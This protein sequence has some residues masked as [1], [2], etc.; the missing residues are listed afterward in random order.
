[1]AKKSN[2][3]PKSKSPGAQ[4]AKAKRTPAKKKH[5]AREQRQA[6]MEQQK[7]RIQAPDP[8]SKE[9]LKKLGLRLGIGAAV[10]WGIAVAIPGTVAKV[11]AGVITVAVLGA[12]V[13]A[14]RF[15]TKSRQVADIVRGADTAEG[16]KEAL[17][18]LDSDFK[19]GDTAATFAKAQLLMQDSPREALEV[20]EGIDLKK[21]MAPL[22]DEAR[23]QRAMLHLMLGETDKARVL[24]DGI[25]LSRHKEAKIRA[26][27]AA[28]VGE[29]W[30]RTGQSRRAIELLETYDPEDADFKDIAP[31]LYRSRAFA[32]SWSNQS[33][34]MKAT[35]R[36]LR[37]INP[38]LLMGFITKKKNPAGVN[39]KG[40]HPALEKAAYNMVM[41][42]GAV[43]RKMQVRRMR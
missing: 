16:R 3:K 43:P 29:A 39:P 22:A 30:S 12:V 13:W 23:S 31:Q 24:A 19:S 36:K 15:A 1:M 11:V 26:T 27:L 7:N 17:E 8:F 5:A 2:S 41:Q 14:M 38:Q 21:V 9:N 18:R 20:L 4:A 34:K 33:K 6:L 28:I 10:L 42:S 35:L 37:S 40:V 25:D 32:Y